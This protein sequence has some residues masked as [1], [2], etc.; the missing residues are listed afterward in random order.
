MMT[1]MD[2]TE[3]AQMEYEEQR[4]LPLKNDL[5][6]YITQRNWAIG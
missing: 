1:A 4:I 3:A 6:H 2:D 5:L